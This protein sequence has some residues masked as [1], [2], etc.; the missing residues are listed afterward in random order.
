ME[1]VGT[2]ANVGDAARSR[3]RQEWRADVKGAEGETE[4]A[5]DGGRGGGG[6]GAE[7]ARR[8][9]E[10]GAVSAF[11]INNR[12]VFLTELSPR[13]P[14]Q[15]DRDEIPVC[16]FLPTG[17]TR[18]SIFARKIRQL[19]PAVE[20]P[21]ISETPAALHRRRIRLAA[22][23]DPKIA[24]TQTRAL[25]DAFSRANSPANPQQLFLHVDRN[26]S[27]AVVGLP[28]PI[29]TRDWRN[30]IRIRR[31]KEHLRASSPRLGHIR[32]RFN[33]THSQLQ[34]RI[35]SCIAAAGHPLRAAPVRRAASA[36]SSKVRVR[37][38]D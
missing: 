3:N 38:L 18:S 26:F 21:E 27:T 29:R 35:M 4:E 19:Y 37:G 7:E 16:E 17:E 14:A 22:V 28:R 13:Q 30:E 23:I 2:E 33:A 1:K 32:T 12:R 15:R 5:N 36:K 34:P 9:R 8:A 24:K 31:V 10:A 6:G 11:L 25:S 20:S